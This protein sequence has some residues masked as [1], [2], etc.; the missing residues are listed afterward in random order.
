MKVLEIE[1]A[2]TT[3]DKLDLAI[4]TF[5]TKLLEAL[6][7]PKEKQEAVGFIL[8]EYVDCCINKYERKKNGTY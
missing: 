3:H 1:M 2:I 5:K 4:T 8:D 7:V 6:G